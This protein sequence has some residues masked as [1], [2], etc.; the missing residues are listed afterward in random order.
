[1]L[2]VHANSETA[3]II[4]DFFGRFL[5]EDVTTYLSVGCFSRKGNAGGKMQLQMKDILSYS[6]RVG[7]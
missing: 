3:L 7:K 6:V 2:Q 5:S 4:S 1:V